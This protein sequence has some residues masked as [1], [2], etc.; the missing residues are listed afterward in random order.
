MMNLLMASLYE[1]FVSH[2]REIKEKINK[3][4]KSNG[5]NNFRQ[6]FNKI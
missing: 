4:S 2:A 6:N 5:L 1:E 3:R